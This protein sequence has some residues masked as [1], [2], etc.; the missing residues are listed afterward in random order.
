MMRATTISLF[1]VSTVACLSACRSSA[2]E[3][4]GASESGRAAASVRDARLEPRSPSA[5]RAAAPGAP[6]SAPGTA[7][8]LAAAPRTLRADD[9]TGLPWRSIGPANMGGRVA[10]IALAPGDAKTFYVGFATGGLWKTTNAGTTFAPIFDEE[11]TAS[12][13]SIAVA[14]APADWRGWKDEASASDAEKSTAAKPAAKKDERKSAQKSETK[15]AHGD[16]KD[17]AKKGRG[18][19][20]WVGTGEGNGRNSSSWGRGVYRSTDSGGTFTQVG[21]ADA[22]DIPALAVDPRDPDVCYAAA[23]GHLWGPNDERGVFKTTDGGKTWQSVLKIDADTGA[24]DVVVD[25]KNSAT[26]YA[27]MYMRRRTAYSYMSGGPQGG[28]YRSDD[29][30]AT[31]K[32]LAAGLP[33]QTGRIGLALFAKDPKIV[34]AVVESDL[35]GRLADSFEDKSRAGGLFRSDDRGESWT[36]VNPYAPRAF[37]FSRVRVDPENAERVY[38]LGW[39]IWIS[40]DGGQHLRAGGARKPHVD[41]HAMAIDPADPEHLIAGNDGGLYISHDGAKTWDFQDHVAVGEFYNLA[42]DSSDPYRIAGGLQDNGTWVGPSSNLLEVEPMEGGPSPGGILNDHWQMVGGGDGFHVA[43]DPTDRNV[44]YVESQGGHISRVHL[45]T[46]VR[47]II[48]PS[49]KEGQRR[50][51]FNWNTPFFVSPHVK[52]GEPTVLY[53]GGNYV[54]RLL[55]GGDRWERISGDLSQAIVDRVDT[56]GSDAETHGTVVSLA[57]SPL[58]RGQLWAGTDDG[59]VHVTADDGKTWSDVTPPQV[60]GHYVSRIEPSHHDA[61]TV[62]AAI[63]GHR[64]D[65]MTANVVATNDAGK[66][67][68]S[69]VGD[70]PADAPVKVIREDPRNA[71]V[72]YAGT[73]TSAFVTIDGGE[74]WVRLNGKSLPTV[75]VDDILV[76]PR[77]HD[78]VAGTHGRSIYVL[79]DAAPIAALTPEVMS[80]PLH[81]FETPPATPRLALPIGGIWTDR[82]FIGANAPLG[83]RITYWISE[84]STDDVKITVTDANGVLVRDISG[85]NRPGFNRVVWDLEREAYDRLP[86]LDKDVGQKQF[87]PP[88]EYDIKVTRGKESAQGTVTVSPAPGSKAK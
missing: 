86:D 78:L 71:K 24:C 83:A 65:V 59:R 68:R 60:R 38:V 47:K 9:L 77:E 33:A 63:D 69:I 82:V 44:M 15:D 66:T 40:D 84:Y 58:A 17:D 53:M 88:G 75:S 22:H 11:A 49:P 57:E 8:S 39:Q 61:S 14:D 34:Y 19:I 67:W 4:K 36:R 5:D 28:I 41:Y 76:H 25:P 16:D 50:F 43:F 56:I 18:K 13:G 73:E 20:V 45:D 26:V 7:K 1:F 46:G 48:M 21:L 52:P 30:G 72:L 87:V 70:L 12:I 31:W 3:P 79:D 23:L 2:H 27:A 64:S 62:Y 81:L 85:T 32:K 55:D 37:Y 54:F 42:V 29:A 35:G 10:A 6:S 51:R 80:K 74:H